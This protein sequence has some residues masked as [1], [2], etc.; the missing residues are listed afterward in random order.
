LFD[1][2]PRAHGQS[3]WSLPKLIRFAMD[4]M[5]AIGSLPLKVWT[6]VGLLLSLASTLYGGM[7]WAQTLIYGIDVPGY[8]SLMV[9]VCFLSGVQL[10]GLGIMGEYMSRIFAEVKQRPMFLVQERIGF[11]Q[12]TSSASRRLGRVAS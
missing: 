7:I 5:T 12:G 4:V 6:Y 2:A 11:D 9:A 3:G 1:V 8:A 10:L